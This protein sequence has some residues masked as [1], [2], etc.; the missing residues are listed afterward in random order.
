VE[1]EIMNEK[2]KLLFERRSIRAFTHEAV[3]K[4]I[5]VEIIKAGMAAP[6]SIDFRPW[7]ITVIEDADLRK[8]IADSSDHKKC[9]SEAP[10]LILV[11]GDSRR[12][13]EG[14]FAR[15]AEAFW[16]Q[17][18]AAMTQNILLAATAFDLGSLW[19]GV[20]PYED[21]IA[22]MRR[23][24]DLPEYLLPFSLIAIG[25]KGEQKEARTQYEQEQVLWK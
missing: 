3:G 20:Y 1:N 6:N 17:D 13:K 18:C 2:L 23:I 10:C 25:H 22:D 8:K 5:I 4:D 12:Y 19:M 14:Q 15:V 16:Q 11:S 7:H 24:I 21:I 9:C